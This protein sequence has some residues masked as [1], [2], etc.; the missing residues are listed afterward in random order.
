VRDAVLAGGGRGPLPGLLG[1]RTYVRAALDVLGAARSELVCRQTGLVALEAALDALFPEATTRLQA[2]GTTGTGGG[3]PGG[4]RARGGEGD[5]RGLRAS[6][7]G[8][9]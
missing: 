9:E 8:E 6:S 1:S 3:D 4:G 7:S 2:P 5:E